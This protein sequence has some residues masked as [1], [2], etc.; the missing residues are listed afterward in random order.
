MRGWM[1]RAGKEGA[2][3]LPAS[4]LCTLGRGVRVPAV[5]EVVSALRAGPRCPLF[6][7]RRHSAPPAGSE[8]VEGRRS[9]DG[10]ALRAAASWAPCADCPSLETRPSQ[11][12]VGGPC[13]RSQGVR[14]TAGGSVGASGTGGDVASA[15]PDR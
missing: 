3:D 13:A 14:F 7:F 6:A 1:R 11:E 12:A 4:P 2:N 8:R 15:R 5:H 9:A 10:G